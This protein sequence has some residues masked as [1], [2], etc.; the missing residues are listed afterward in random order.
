MIK[1]GPLIATDYAQAA[2][3][4]DEQEE[5]VL[6]VRPLTESS[7][8]IRSF[9]FWQHWVPCQFHVTPSIYVAREEGVVLGFISLRNTNKAKTCWRIDNLVV[10]PE[11]RGRGIAHEL[12]RYAFAQFGSQGVSHF[13]A[14][15]AARND[16]AL[17][18][19]ASGGFCRTAQVTYYKL[20]PRT[21]VVTAELEDTSDAHFRLA[22]Q[23]HQYMLYVLHQDVLP[24]ELRQVLSQTSEDFRVKEMVPFTSVERNKNRLMRTRIWY[25]ICEEPERKALPAAAKVTARPGMGYKVEFAIHPGYKHLTNELVNFTVSNIRAHMPQLPIWVRVYDFHPEVH[26][27][28]K[29]LGFERSGDYFLVTREHW[30][31]AKRLKRAVSAASLNPITKPAINFPLP[32]QRQSL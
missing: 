4:L 28:V 6:D 5:P 27:A 2:A 21:P 14:E 9:A 31:R 19:F 10:H 12:L 26:E 18:L 3:L 16:G 32:N 29:K 11:H 23:R 24:A 17:S 7:L 25:W 8:A 22:T 30:Q 15:I 13:I 20:E 1:I